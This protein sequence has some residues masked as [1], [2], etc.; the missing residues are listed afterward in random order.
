MIILTPFICENN[1]AN[2]TII[3]KAMADYVSEGKSRYFRSAESLFTHYFILFNSIGY[4]I[5][6]TL[7]EKTNFYLTSHKLT[8]EYQGKISKE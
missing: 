6:R 1:K 5:L 4:I 8:W 7:S 3:A 2:Q